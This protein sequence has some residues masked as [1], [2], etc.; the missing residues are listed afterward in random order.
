MPK[1]KNFIGARLSEELKQRFDE[2]L[3]SSGKSQTEV[4]REAI[5]SYLNF[6][7]STI[8]VDIDVI[9][10][11]QNRV[12]ALE[13]RAERASRDEVQLEIQGDDNQTDIKS[14]NNFENNTDI[15]SDNT[16]KLWSH[17]EVEAMPDVDLSYSGIQY[18]HQQRIVI[19][20]SDGRVLEPIRVRNV[21]RWK[22]R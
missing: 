2:H 11:L 21:P 19:T 16:K 5:S 22:V 7:P 20:L 8:T 17:K 13:E 4:V 15:T 1:N 18:R 10:D 6:T 12:K 9:T 14:D 3:E